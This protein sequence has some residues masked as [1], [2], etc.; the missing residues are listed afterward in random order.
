MDVKFAA[1]GN[2]YADAIRRA[3]EAPQAHGPSDGAEGAAGNAASFSDMLADATRNASGALE[4]SEA[5]GIK[6]IGG[7]AGLT[8]VVTA[9]SSAEVTV[10][11]VVAVRDRM[12][13]AYQEIMKMPI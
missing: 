10:R 11:T 12:L 5:M 8:D 6:A 13:Q 3:A 2:A 4:K 9:V 1:A 7:E